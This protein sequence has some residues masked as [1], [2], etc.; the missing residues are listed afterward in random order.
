M[1]MD[2]FLEEV[3]SKKQSGVQTAAHVLAN[4]MMVVFALVAVMLI[5]MIISYVA[6][7][8][9]EVGLIYHIVLFLVTGGSAVLLFL[10][11]D[12]IKT[13]YEYTFT[14]GTLDFAQVFNNKK[15][16]ALGTMN[17]KNI[18]ACGKVSSGSFSRYISKPG[19]KKSNWFVNREADLFYL[20]FNKENQPRIIIIEPQSEEMVNLIKGAVMPG[21]YQVN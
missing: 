18:E 1:A 7:Y 12:T 9:F 8:G 2:H 3:A 19:I 6:Q 13:E 11:R 15:R 16:K 20:Y 10:K 17:L 14:N 21:V 5:N 4:I